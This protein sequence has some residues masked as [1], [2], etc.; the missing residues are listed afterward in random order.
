MS[1]PL[2]FEIKTKSKNWVWKPDGR[3]DTGKRVLPAGAAQGINSTAYHRYRAVQQTTG[4]P[5]VLLVIIIPT[6]EMIANSLDALGEPFP[7]VQPEYPL[8]NWPKSHF[9]PLYNFN[10]EQLDR[11]FYKPPITGSSIKRSLRPPLHMPERHLRQL[12]FDRLQP[13]Q[14]ELE[15]FRERLFKHWNDRW[16]TTGKA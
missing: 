7:S 6:G 12:W 3:D 11:Y 16:T 2:W 13:T 10:I 8:V 14:M 9:I 1:K 15:G 4:L 5:V